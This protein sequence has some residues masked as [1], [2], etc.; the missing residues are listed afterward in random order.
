MVRIY[1]PSRTGGR[2]TEIEVDRGLADA[3]R[4]A[5]G[6]VVAGP[7]EPIAF[8]RECAG[9]EAVDDEQLD[10]PAAFRGGCVPAWL[11]TH[12]GPTERLVRA[13][14]VNGLPEAEALERPEPRRRS[15]WE[16]T[17]PERR[18][19]LARGPD[20]WTGRTLDFAAPFALGYAGLILGGHGAGL[21]RTLLA[22][23]D[24]VARAA[25]D[26]L[27]IV[28]LMRARGEEATEWRRRF[29]AAEVI[30][31]PGASAEESLR[32][33]DLALACAMRQTELGR[34]V[35]LAVDSLT[36][37]WAAMLESEEADA[38]RE[39]DRSVARLRVRE[40]L[41][42]SGSFSGEML[43]GRG[44]GGSLTL[45]GTVWAR[46]VDA[47]AE[48]EGELHPHLRLAEHVLHLAGWRVAL[49]TPLAEARLFPAID[50]ARCLSQA[51]D[52]LLPEDLRARVEDARAA[53]ARMD[54]AAAYRAW[55]SALSASEG[56]GQALAVLASDAGPSHAPP[57][58]RALF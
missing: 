34:D 39:A 4:L 6:D 16:R 29:P 25:P 30:A 51:E 33:A 18:V 19:S 14:R 47:E 57:A 10:E 35:L 32:F 46:E 2:A 21:T 56:P 48:E 7:T 5:S 50:I 28:L 9:P 41:Q 31:C 44:P 55:T 15:A 58:W 26:V 53:L 3:L 49:S 37:L 52:R 1:R 12:I 13:D 24:G 43:G 36:A 23:V 11:A 40:W 42:Q 38:Q 17:P 27:P 54:P 8:A 22:V 20:D 45:V